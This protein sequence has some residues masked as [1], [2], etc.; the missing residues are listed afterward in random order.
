MA[1]DHWIKVRRLLLKGDEA[2][3][4]RLLAIARGIDP[5]PL[6]DR[7]RSAWG[8]PAAEMRDDLKRLAD[9]IDVRAQQPATMVALART[10]RRARHPAAA[11]RLL[12][13]A[14]AASPNDF[15]LSFELSSVTTSSFSPLA[16]RA[17]ASASRL[18]W[19]LSGKRKIVDSLWLRLVSSISS[20]PQRSALNGDFTSMKPS[21]PWKTMTWRFA[22]WVAI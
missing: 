9:S 1:L 3:W 16:A 20:A 18:Y 12:E 7:L 13:D 22:I 4:K 5:D 2:G 10:L 11:V 15:W 8:R 19:R 14:Q 6:R 21:V 17:K